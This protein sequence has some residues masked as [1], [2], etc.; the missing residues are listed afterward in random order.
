MGVTWGSF[1]KWMAFGFIYSPV[2][3]FVYA[4]GERLGVDWLWFSNRW[5]FSFVMGIV[6]GVILVISH[7]G[8]RSIG[9]T[10]IFLMALALASLLKLLLGFLMRGFLMRE[11]G[12]TVLQRSL[13]LLNGLVF[14]C[15][16]GAV[17][18]FAYGGAQRLGV[19]WL[20]FSN[21]W[22]FC[23]IFGFTSPFIYHGAR[24][25]R[26]VRKAFFERVV[27]WV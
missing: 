27:F 26:V 2:S 16:V 13:W 6:L 21:Q 9:L 18:G 22:V 12:D 20:W 15:I 1:W 5:V 17:F 25:A 8:A 11:R 24:C 19:D 23:L 3:R 14:S 4:E 10:G 7:V